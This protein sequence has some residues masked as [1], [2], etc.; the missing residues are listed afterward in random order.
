M[1]K[2]RK[3]TQIPTEEYDMIDEVLAELHVWYYAHIDDNADFDMEDDDPTL[4]AFLQERDAALMN[5]YGKLREFYR[6]RRG[7]GEP[8]SQCDRR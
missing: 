6:L 8:P 3:W 7:R 2:K 5:K 4:L 1:P